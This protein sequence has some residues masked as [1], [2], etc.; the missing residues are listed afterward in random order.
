MDEAIDYGWDDAPQRPFCP[1]CRNFGVAW[2]GYCCE[3]E[4]L[5]TGW[6]RE[7]KMDRDLRDEIVEQRAA[8]H[9]QVKH[10]TCKS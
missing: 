9:N 3:T 4:E 6:D 8:A 1:R 10:G 5:A 2:D 7:Q